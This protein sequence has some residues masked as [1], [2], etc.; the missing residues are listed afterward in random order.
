MTRVL[1]TPRLVRRWH[2]IGPGSAAMDAAEQRG[3]GLCQHLEPGAGGGVAGRAA[4]TAGGHA[5]AA[6]ADSA[7]GGHHGPRHVGPAEAA[8]AAG[9]HLD[10]R[11]VWPPPCTHAARALAPGTGASP[12]AGCGQHSRVRWVAVQAC[13]TSTGL[14]SPLPESCDAAASSGERNKQL[15]QASGSGLCRLQP[16]GARRGR[17]GRPWA[18]LSPAHHLVA[19]SCTEA[20]HALL[21]RI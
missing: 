21:C 1:D 15:S 3:R 4:P 6:A 12:C 11:C 9:Q 8:A 16:L 14:P 19:R 10:R 13:R 7:P 2:S 17:K 5:G 20:A 18:S